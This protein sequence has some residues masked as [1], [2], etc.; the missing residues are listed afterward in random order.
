MR[1]AVAAG[2]VVLRGGEHGPEVVLA[3]RQG[4]WVLPKGTPNGE[5]PIEE[6]AMREV[7][8]ETGLDVRIVR[9]IGEIEYWFALP[10]RR[11]HKI[12]HFFLME[13]LGGDTSRHDHEYDEVR[14]VPVEDARRML[15]FDTYREMLERALVAEAA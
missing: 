2:G 3:G 8:E 7:R 11:V 1:E 13:A 15:T 10:R 4:M 5:E 9:P 12:V 6:C 14:W